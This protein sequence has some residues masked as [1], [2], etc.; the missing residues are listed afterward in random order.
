MNE[1]LCDAESLDQYV[2]S[3]LHDPADPPHEPIDPETAA[4]LQKVVKVETALSDPPEVTRRKIWQQVMAHSTGKPI[5]ARPTIVPMRKVRLV[6][7]LAAA[8]IVLLITGAV[9]TSGTKPV[10]AAE[11]LAKAQQVEANPTAF[12]LRSYYG[13]IAGE[14]HAYSTDTGLNRGVS[15][16]KDYQWFQAP[17]RLR[18]EHYTDCFCVLHPKH[19]P[20]PVPGSQ[21]T[22]STATPGVVFR[23]MTGSDGTTGWYY[24]INNL[25]IWSDAV[26]RMQS[27]T[28]LQSTSLKSLLQNVG[29]QAESVKLVGTDSVLGRSVYV[30]NVTRKSAGENDLPFK[31]EQLKVDQET[32]ITLSTKI[33]DNKGN[34]F[35]SSEFTSLEINPVLDPGLFTF[36]PPKDAKIHDYRTTDNEA[37]ILRSWHQA[38]ID[39]S[40]ALYKPA[41][42]P[43]SMKVSRAAYEDTSAPWPSVRQQYYTA[44][45]DYAFLLMEST[46]QSGKPSYGEKVTAGLYT[47]DYWEQF[48]TRY[49]G[50]NI[51]TTHILMI[52]SFNAISK[53]DLLKVAAS[54]QKVE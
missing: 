48:G 23:S 37:E 41:S 21:Y 27:E 15:I 12:G 6:M 47:A 18:I 4:M 9:I 45:G 19:I 2:D 33:M 10:S 43:P 1:N 17:N 13:E 5:I 31:Y 3:L 44:D 36:N 16:S 8:A 54:L 51:E 7:G 46:Q 29:E 28:V 30:L 49:L 42:W 35:Y 50:I 25:F 38:S 32:Y 24:D 34:I 52:A 40:F 14:T 39:A 26:V 22:L 20:T 53:E 11:I